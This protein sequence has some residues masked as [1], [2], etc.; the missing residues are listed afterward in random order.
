LERDEAFVDRRQFAPLRIA[1]REMSPQRAMGRAIGI[2]QERDVVGLQA[3]RPRCHQQ[4]ERLRADQRV[5]NLGPVFAK[6]RRLIHGIGS[7]P[8]S[9]SSIGPR[10]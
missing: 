8:T 1:A 5:L 10:S 6:V 3:A 4:A 7:R 2:D 9:P